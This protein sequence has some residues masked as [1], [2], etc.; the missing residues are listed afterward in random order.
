MKTSHIH[1]LSGTFFQG[2][3]GSSAVFDLF[4]KWSFIYT[5]KAYTGL[6]EKILKCDNQFHSWEEQPEVGG[7]AH[8]IQQNLKSTSV[9]I[10]VL[11]SVI[12]IK[13]TLK[14]LILLFSMTYHFADDSR[15][16]IIFHST[17]FEQ[18]DFSDLLSKNYH[19]KYY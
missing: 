19:L 8:N 17:I 7:K 9:Q 11:P 13:F 4:S 2:R 15:L 10:I 6:W 5:E 1:Y 16:S 3:A 14:T 12:N 18:K